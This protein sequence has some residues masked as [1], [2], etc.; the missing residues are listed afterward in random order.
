MTRTKPRLRHLIVCG[1]ILLLGSGLSGCLNPSG[2]NRRITIRSDPPGALVLV[3]GEE[4]GYTPVSFDFTYYGTREFT[5]VKDGFETL[6]V[7]QKVAPPWYQRVPIDFV[8]D[9]FSPFKI[10]DR[11]DYTYRLQQQAIV[12]NQDL[13]QRAEGLRT[14][15]H[16]PE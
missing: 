9:N 14:E 8:S 2:M 5:L 1:A 7:M 10:R 11:R 13:L 6:T 3:E 16:V 4:L 15:A 12:G